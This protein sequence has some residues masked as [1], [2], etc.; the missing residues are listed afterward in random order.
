MLD[1]ILQELLDHKG[2]S[3]YRDL[4]PD[5]VNSKSIS[6][7]PLDEAEAAINELILE[8]RVEELRWVKNKLGVGSFD[9]QRIKDRLKTLKDKAK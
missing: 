6:W 4:E 7:T 9:M 8:A 2:V 5:K 1:E 3:Y